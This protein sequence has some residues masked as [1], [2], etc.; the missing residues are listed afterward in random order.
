VIRGLT[1]P[2]RLQPG[3]RIAAV[4]LSWGGPGAFP[5]RY[6]AGARQLEEAFGVTV[7]PTQHALREPEWIARHPQARA[8]DLLAAFADPDIDGIVATIGGDDSIRILPFLDLEVIATNPKVF[9]GFSD[10][11]IT[12]LACLR[13]GL[14]SFYGPSIMAGFGENT[15][16]FPYLAE[17]VRR[18][19]FEPEPEL[20]WPENRDGWTVEHLDWADPSLQDHPRAR[21][22]SSGW[23]WHGGGTAEGPIVA[24]CLEV[25]EWVRGSSWF[26]DLDGAVLATET[27]E[28]GPPPAHVAR[29]LRSLAVTGELE[30]L[31][32]IVFG[33]P[34][35]ADVSLEEHAAY[36]D[37]IL[38][39][40]RS[41]Q[42]LA[43]IPIVT[44]VDFGHT[45]PTWT[46]PI[47]VPTR[48][49][50]GARTVTFLEA[51][52]R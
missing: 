36:D 13:A 38:A 49:D 11:T 30:G 45:D 42:G 2:P 29:F 52:V 40:V 44:G 15:G 19:L 35:G 9:L 37:A 31:A 28:E 46:I 27:S 3:S 51:G 22:A 20:I 14:T 43:D 16:L 21:T 10:T 32:A 47:G 12:H 23:R 25:L 41:E 39:V 7:V 33:R 48:V 8:E 34:G 1:R 24:G 5:H 50:P 18:T 4:T 26:P 17:G 6:E